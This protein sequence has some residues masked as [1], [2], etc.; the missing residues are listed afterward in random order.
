MKVFGKSSLKQVINITMF[1]KQLNYAV[2]TIVIINVLQKRA[3]S[4]VNISIHVIVLIS[5]EWVSTFIKPI[6]TLTGNLCS[7]TTVIAVS[8]T[9]FL[10]LQKHH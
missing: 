1:P 4:Y 2:M 8:L 5:I 3:W 9:A 6:H 7:N 10:I